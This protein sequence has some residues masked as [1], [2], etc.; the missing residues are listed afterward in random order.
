VIQKCTELVL[1]PRQLARMIASG[2]KAMQATF[3]LKYCHRRWG[4]AY[5]TTQ[6]R[7][8]GVKLPS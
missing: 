8:S 2:L 4:T 6:L 5:I 1:N 3:P 7:V